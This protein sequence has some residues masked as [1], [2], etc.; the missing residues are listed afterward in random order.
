MLSFLWQSQAIPYDAEDLFSFI[1]THLDEVGVGGVLV[2]SESG[3]GGVGGIG[4]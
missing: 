1:R 4:G 2:L 3:V